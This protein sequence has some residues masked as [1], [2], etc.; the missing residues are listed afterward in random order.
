MIPSR[1]APRVAL[2]SP[3]SFTVSTVIHVEDSYFRSTSTVSFSSAMGAKAIAVM[4]L[5]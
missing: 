1:F 2:F 3:G 5:N 4:L